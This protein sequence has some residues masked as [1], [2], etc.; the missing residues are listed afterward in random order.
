MPNI[1]KLLA[2]TSF[3]KKNFRR[4]DY[5]VK[6]PINCLNPSIATKKRKPL[7]HLHYLFTI[8]VPQ[9]TF[10]QFSGG[11]L[12]ISTQQDGWR[13]LRGKG[14]VM[15]KKKAHIILSQEL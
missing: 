6:N 13:F 9:Q 4:Q 3:P 1:Q 5:L 11:G 15:E 2:S 7:L 10:L 14:E 12:E 8:T